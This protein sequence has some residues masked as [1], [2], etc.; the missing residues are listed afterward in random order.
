VFPE[1]RALLLK[2]S[3]VAS[4]LQKALDPMA[5]RIELAFVFGSL[6]R[7][8]ATPQ[9]D[10]DVI[11]VGNTTLHDIVKALSPLQEAIGREINPTVYSVNRSKSLAFAA[12]A[13]RRAVLSRGN[14]LFFNSLL[15]SF[16]VKRSKAIISSTPF[17]KSP[18]GF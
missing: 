17:Y 18:N 14:R 3:G 4:Q 6:P 15:K 11:I 13:F 7:G 1:L 8:D 9:S 5:D 12:C 16:R 10:V 2:T